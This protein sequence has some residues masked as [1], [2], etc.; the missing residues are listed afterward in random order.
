MDPAPPATDL[1][2]TSEASG[3]VAALEERSRPIRLRA[4]ITGVVLGLSLAAEYPWLNAIMPR[5]GQSPEWIGG[6]LPVLPM[7]IFAMVALLWN[8]LARWVLVPHSHPPNS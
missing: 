2:P 6:Y 5:G 4:W 3:Q 8:P 1:T 7:L